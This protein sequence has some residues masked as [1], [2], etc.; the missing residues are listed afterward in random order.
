MKEIYLTD[1]IDKN[2][3]QVLQDGF[4]KMT[5]MAALTTDKEGKPVTEPSNFTDFCMNKVRKSK[6]GSQ[7]C[8][9]CDRRGANI[10]HQNGKPRAYYCHSGLIDFAAPIVADGEIVGSII[11]GQ[12][13]PAKPEERYFREKAKELEIEPDTLIDSLRDVKIM[14]IH[15]INKAAEYL[16]TVASVMSKL[17]VRQHDAI[18]LSIEL[19]HAAHLKADFLANMSHEIRTPMNAV[20]GMAEMALREDIPDTARE[21]IMQIKSSGKTLL[22]IIND[23]LDFS[24]IESG[25]MELNETEY[26]I[27]SIINDI[28]G[29]I[30]TR[31]GE[32][33][34]ELIVNADPNLPY[35]L[36]GDDIRIKQMITNLANNAVKF[37]R[38]GAVTLEMT[39]E[40]LDDKNIWLDVSVRDTGIGIKEE[41]LGKLFVSFQQV[42]SKRNRNIEGTGLGLVITQQLACLMNGGV[43]VQ[44]V[45]G[46]GSLFHFRIPQRIVDPRNAAEVRGKADIFAVGMFRN[47]YLARSWKFCLEL[48]GIRYELISTQEEL[49]A[50]KSE[51]VNYFFAEFEC[52][53]PELREFAAREK[54][55]TCV[56]VIAPFF[57]V[58]DRENFVWLKKPI[59]CL[60]LAAVFNRENILDLRIGDGSDEISFEAP[61]AKVL[62]VDDNTINLTVAEGLLKPLDMQIDTASSGKMA[63]KM[64]QEKEYDLIFMDHMMPEMDGVEAAHFLRQLGGIYE[65]IPIIALTANAVGGAKEMFLSEGMNDFVP[66]PIEVRTIVAKLKQWLPPEKIHILTKKEQEEQ[67]EDSGGKQLVLEGIDVAQGMSY[68][69]T[70]EL[71][72]K[73]LRD[74]YAVIEKKAALIEEY[75]KK[76]MVPEYTIEVHALK[77]ASRLIGAEELAKQAEALE[78][79]GHEGNLEMIHE[80]TGEMLSMYLKFLDVLEDYAPEEETG[81]E[82]KVS[83]SKEEFADIYEQMLEAADMLD[84]DL[85]EEM[86]DLLRQYLFEEKEREYFL[87]AAEAVQ[88]ID[89]ET[90]VQVMEEWRELRE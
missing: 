61:E 55:I 1:L 56:A 67:Q 22:A 9:E 31:I 5:G 13:L 77:S 57:K 33:E 25:K 24:K 43:D 75:G 54:G 70:P 83:I 3:L 69:G 34:I 10:S 66:K 76:E 38:K 73:V 79:A 18:A 12:V 26:E 41:D 80:K 37:T 89:T 78:A 45:Y 36:Y 42:D 19:E 17:A 88:N 85:M 81:G 86:V 52:L 11:G 2:T 35:K 23:I 39:F 15:Q 27:M 8:R 90:L 48:Y 60:N 40:P 53:T 71:Y 65:S 84:L 47:D 32:K 20:I 82:G 29:I 30:E 58:E 6:L 7:R 49:E 87:Q 51:G 14:D 46:K 44:S 21:Y 62:I 16:G 4:S 74:Y 59:Y 72:E 28:A 63:I 64:A 50:F 68:A